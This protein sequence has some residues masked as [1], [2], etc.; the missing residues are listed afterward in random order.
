M[1]NPWGLHTHLLYCYTVYT[2]AGMANEK[3]LRARKKIK[4]F[5][6]HLLIYYIIFFM[7]QLKKKQR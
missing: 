7:A 6:L 4:I 5:L 1:M 3:I 2:I